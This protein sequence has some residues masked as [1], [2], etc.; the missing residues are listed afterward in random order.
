LGLTY[1]KKLAGVIG[2][3]TFILQREK[4]AEIISKSGN[5][6]TPVLM[7]HGTADQVVRYQWGKM[8][9]DGIKK[10][11]QDNGSGNNQVQFKTYN[12]MGHSA[13]QQELV[14]VVQFLKERV[15]E[16]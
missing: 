1:E 11:L 4:F 3:S 16:K 10:I 14:D 2:M 12:G 15:P 8:T 7:C 9:F 13:C 6:D 5:L